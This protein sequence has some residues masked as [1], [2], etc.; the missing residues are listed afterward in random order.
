MTARMALALSAVLLAV[1]NQ[2]ASRFV[3]ASVVDPATGVPLGG[4]AA[5]DFVVQEGATRCETIAVTPAHYPV[6]LLVDTSQAARREFMPIRQAVHQLVSRLSG[7]DVAVYTFGDRAFRVADF[8]RDTTKL[9]HAVDQLFAQP[10]GESH[11]LDAVIEAAKDLSRREPAVAMIVVVSAGGNDQSNRTPREVFDAVM[12]SRSVVHVVEMRS[13]GAS[14]RL[15]N[16]RGRRNFTT[17][18]AAEAALGLQEL[19]QGLVDRTR[20][21]YDRVFAATGYGLSLE[22]LQRRLGAEVVVE[23]A[24]SGAPPSDLRLGSRIAGATVKGLGLDRA[25]K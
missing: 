15:G 16:V 6:A 24:S 20:G 21:D 12:P 5:E 25:P 17:D 14:G 19:L 3:L 10:D 11:V 13:I 9:E 7:R 2:S 23:Y 22:R 4:L 1:P 18:R 8:T